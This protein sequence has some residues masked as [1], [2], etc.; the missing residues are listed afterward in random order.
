MK[1]IKSK[2]INKNGFA[3]LFAVLTASLI[4]TIGISIFSISFKELLISTNSR[5]SQVAFYAADSAREC[6][7]YWSNK[8]GE[9]PGCSNAGCTN[10]SPSSGVVSSAIKCNGAITN[11]SYSV[12][13]SKITYQ[14]PA[15]PFIKYGTELEP[16]A[17]VIITKEYE[18]MDIIFS[19]QAFGHNVGSTGRRIERGIEQ[20]GYSL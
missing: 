9:F 2:K 11:L 20:T 13:A 7:L 17:N 5:E 8:Q 4:L 18:N 16:E 6:A 19:I 1:F 3:M 10:I 12:D 15:L 14:N